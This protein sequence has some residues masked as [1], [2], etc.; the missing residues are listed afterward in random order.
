GV[1]GFFARPCVELEV[2]S[3][4]AAAVVAAPSLIDVHDDDEPAMP[5]APQ[6]ADERLARFA[7]QLQ[8]PPA[9]ALPPAAV[10]APA[11]RPTPNPQVTD[12]DPI[13]EGDD[14]P[15]VW[16]G[17][18]N[19]AFVPSVFDQVETDYPSHRPLPAV[20]APPAAASLAVTSA[21]WP[22]DAHA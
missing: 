16:P 9:Q 13:A 7:E 17:D 8:S 11:A 21:A 5:P 18:E 14:A 3:G 12:L 2:T 19:D 4:S 20:T 15:V 10:P 1:G 6:P 22:A